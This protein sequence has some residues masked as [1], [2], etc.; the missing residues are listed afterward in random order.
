MQLIVF[1]RKGSVPFSVCVNGDKLLMSM[2]I[3]N[4]IT[5][6][7]SPFCLVIKIT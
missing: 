6:P 7:Q 2:G 1:F 5:I 3:H 4:V